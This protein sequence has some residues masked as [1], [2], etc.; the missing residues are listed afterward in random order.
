MAL[1]KKNKRV[2]TFLTALKSKEIIAYPKVDM[3]I[4]VKRQEND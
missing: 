3:Y 1:S 2:Q 4:F